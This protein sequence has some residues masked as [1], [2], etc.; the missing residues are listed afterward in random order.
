[1][2]LVTCYLGGSTYISLELGL[3]DGC[4]AWGIPSGYLKWGKPSFITRQYRKILPGW[5]RSNSSTS[6]GQVI[7]SVSLVSSL[8]Q[9]GK[10]GTYLLGLS[11][12][13][14]QVIP[15]KCLTS[16]SYNI[17]VKQ[18]NFTL[19]PCDKEGH[20]YFTFLTHREQARGEGNK[21]STGAIKWILAKVKPKGAEER[22]QALVECLSVRRG[23]WVTQEW[24]D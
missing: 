13:L 3:G 5:L 23:N 6:C 7:I 22:A 17:T 12:G 21:Q 1:M 19:C 18:Y 8:V 15:G 20:F 11:R 10:N 4:S 14:N 2:K 16:V 9:M 24:E